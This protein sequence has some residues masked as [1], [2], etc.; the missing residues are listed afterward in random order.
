MSTQIIELPNILNISDD[1]TY[2]TFYHSYF[3]TGKYIYST[4]T[5]AWFCYDEDNVLRLSSTKT[6]FRLKNEICKNF[7]SHFRNLQQRL[8]EQETECY[9]AINKTI[10]HVGSTSFAD[11]VITFLRPMN[12]SDNL[13]S[14]I[15]SNQE[16][17]AFNNGI[18]FDVKNNTYRDIEKTISFQRPCLFRFPSNWTRKQPTPF[19]ISLAASSRTR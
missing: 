9:D 13:E 11:S 10:K 4:H 6:P 8:R 18:L 12:S 15:D 16:L 2:A 3:D 1:Y 5:G 14:T 7:V 19:T 17:M